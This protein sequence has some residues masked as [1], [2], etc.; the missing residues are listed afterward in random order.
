[1]PAL[2]GLPNY[3]NGLLKQHETSLLDFVLVRSEKN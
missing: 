2:D 3:L 1:M